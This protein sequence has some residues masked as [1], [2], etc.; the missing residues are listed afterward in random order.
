MADDGSRGTGSG[1]VPWEDPTASFPHGLAGTWRQSLME[2]ERFFARV[3]YEGSFLRPLL[4]FLLVV[5]AWA[6]LSTA[7]QLAVPS[8]IPGLESDPTGA[9][10]TFFVTPFVAVA[11]LVAATLAVLA[12]LGLA[13][14]G[15]GLDATARVLC[16]AS[17]TLVFAVVPL[18][19]FVAAAGWGLVIQVAG[20]REAH[21]VRTGAAVLA[22][23][24][25]ALVGAGL[26]VAAAL[27]AL[28]LADGLPYP[29]PPGS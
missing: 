4:Y 23:L 13:G 3:D 18:V 22:A 8:P 7:W 2:P 24:V 16:Y 1:P 10:L 26:A 19:G 6:G 17:G 11:G 25:P 20:L 29:W 21:R 9:A 27:A 12:G 14:A 5:V 15:R 28:E